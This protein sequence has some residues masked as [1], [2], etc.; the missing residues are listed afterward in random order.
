MSGKRKRYT[1]EFQLNAARMVVEEGFARIEVTEKLGV[2]AWSVGRWIARF[3]EAGELGREPDEVPPEQE[4]AD[5][6]DELRQLRK[7]VEQLRLENEIL[8]KATAYFA[9]ES[10]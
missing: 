1:R 4:S 6:A 8:K 5:P 2:S 10:L 7:Q 3:Q 9:K